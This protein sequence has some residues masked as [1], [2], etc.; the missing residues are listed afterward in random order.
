MTLSRRDVGVLAGSAAAL[1]AVGVS[2]LPAHAEVP[3]PP[4]WGT[5]DD[6]KR[7][8]NRT[9][10]TERLLAYR[11]A[12]KTFGAAVVEYATMALGH[13]EQGRDNGGPFVDW[14]TQT[15]PSVTPAWCAAFACATWFF[16]SYGLQVPAPFKTWRYGS[17]GGVD[18][19]LWVPT[20]ANNAKAAG[21]FVSGYSK[22]V[23]APG[24]LL[25]VKDAS[26]GWSHV[27]VVESID[28]N[29]VTAIEGNVGAKTSAT[30]LDTVTRITRYRVSCDFGAC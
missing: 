25:F 11:P 29:R 2:G 27:G 6:I 28:A 21:R 20:L 5:L 15:P 7:P 3:M 19:E 10:L 18:P 26:L 4:P 23:V 13:G 9:P 1:S 22:D 12:A 30:G 16:A 14:L 8:Q 17:D 24:S